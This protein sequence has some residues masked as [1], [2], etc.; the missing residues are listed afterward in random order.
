MLNRRQGLVALAALPVVLRT[1]QA[2]NPL[3]L[4]STTSTQDSG[5]LRDL[6]PRFQA[7]TGIQ[8]RAI[9]LGTGQAL[10][11]ARRGDVDL[12]LV[13]AR[14]EE[15]AFVAQGY[16]LWRRPVMYNDF[17][18]VGPRHDPAGIAGLADAIA[19]FDRIRSSGQ[20]FISRGDRSG[21][22]LMELE[23][24]R[25][26]SVNP[27]ILDKTR[28][29]PIG[30]GQGA[31]LAIAGELNAYL[32]VDRGTWIAFRNKRELA[33]LCE[34]SRAL[35]NQYGVIPVH[36][37]R[38]PHVH[39]REAL[40]FADWITGARGQQAISDFRIDGQQLFFPNSGEAGA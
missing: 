4:V 22:H 17:V 15:E 10:E 18:I 2:A 1:A 9:S 28:Y 26:L 31:A 33:L 8:V 11:V 29:R 35:R 6:L 7:D 27:D 21:T 32:L 24:W 3:K 13:H 34:G 19:A 37:A 30:Q 14:S 20:V 39:S 36:P 23:I 5:L 25:S 12:V 40:I 38:H 16:G